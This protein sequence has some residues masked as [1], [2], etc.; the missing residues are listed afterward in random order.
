MRIHSDEANEAHIAAAMLSLVFS[1]P[2]S[3]L[4]FS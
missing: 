4:A 1:L 2:T 3:P